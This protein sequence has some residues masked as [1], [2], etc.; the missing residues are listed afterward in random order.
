MELRKNFCALDES[1]S[2]GTLIG[3]GG[4]EARLCLSN[5]GQS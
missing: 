4:R 2:D 1:K 3:V 5:G